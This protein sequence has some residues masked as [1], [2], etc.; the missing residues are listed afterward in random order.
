MNTDDRIMLG[1]IASCLLWIVIRNVL[2]YFLSKDWTPVW[3]DR[4]V[5]VYR[6]NLGGVE[7]DDKHLFYEILYSPSRKTFKLISSGY[8]AKAHHKYQTAVEKL[9][10]LQKEL[11]NE[12]DN[13]SRSR[14]KN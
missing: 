13:K 8:K 9:V 4:G 6:N 3:T 14:S 1:V 12:Q 7:G 10:E 5:W 2:H 11:N